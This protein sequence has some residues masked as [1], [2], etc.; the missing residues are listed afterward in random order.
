MT[1]DEIDKIAE[2]LAANQGIKCPE[3]GAAIGVELVS[4]AMED[5]RVSFSL[6]P[7]SGEMLSAGNVGK[8]LAA[9]EGIFVAIGK[10]LGVKTTVSVEGI[11]FADGGVKFNLL[12]ARHE[13]PVGKRVAAA[14]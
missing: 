7:H 5:S 2:K 13:R 12:L 9:M 10:E 11:E 6:Q 8:A 4:K 3:C 1:E 14:G